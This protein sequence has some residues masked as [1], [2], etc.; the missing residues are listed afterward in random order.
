MTSSIPIPQRS[1]GCFY[2]IDP[3]YYSRVYFFQYLDHFQ[4]EAVVLDVFQWLL[5]TVISSVKAIWSCKSDLTLGSTFEWQ[6][7]RNHP[8]ALLERNQ[9]QVQQGSTNSQTVSTPCLTMLLNSCAPSPLCKGGHAHIPLFGLARSVLRTRSVKTSFQ[10]I[11]WYKSEG[12]MLPW[13]RSIFM[14]GEKR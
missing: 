13:Y 6:G 8:S 4:P 2:Q 11:S 9:G 3:R 5:W 1:W 12:K 14:Y 10:P 7:Y